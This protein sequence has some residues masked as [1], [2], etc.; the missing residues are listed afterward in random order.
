MN[1]QKGDRAVCGMAQQPEVP[2]LEQK[3]VQVCLEKM[4]KVN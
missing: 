1:F 4:E 2:Y 3:E